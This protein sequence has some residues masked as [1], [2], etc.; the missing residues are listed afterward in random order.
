MKALW[1]A[2]LARPDIAKTINDLSC[3]ITNWTRND[4]KHLFRLYCYIDT[5]KN[6]VL[7]GYIKDDPKL[8]F[9]RLYTDADFSGD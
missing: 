2:R 1:L 6:K 9:L 4:D 8:L 3:K 5:T 7:S